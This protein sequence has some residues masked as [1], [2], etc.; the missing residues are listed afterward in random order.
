MKLNLKPFGSLRAKIGLLSLALLAQ[1]TFAETRFSNEFWVSTN[2]NTANSGTLDNP[3]D[4]STQPKFDAVLANLPTNSTLH[5]LAGTY[6]TLGTTY[7]N[8]GGGSLQTGQKILG[9]GIDNTILQIVLGTVS[10]SAGETWVLSTQTRS[11]LQ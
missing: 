2:V 3:Y 4:G 1:A 8:N 9:S 5:I 11:L 6:H 7:Y 10:A